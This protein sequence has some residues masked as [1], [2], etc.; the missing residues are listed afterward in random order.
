MDNLQIIRSTI[1]KPLL[2]LFNK[3]LKLKE[4]KKIHGTQNII[5]LQKSHIGIELCWL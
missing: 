4:V 2:L 3:Y 1:G 5:Q